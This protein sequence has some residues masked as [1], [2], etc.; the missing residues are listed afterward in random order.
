MSNVIKF[1][2][3]DGAENVLL[4]E[5]ANN[6]SDL[7]LEHG[8]NVALGAVCLAA[9]RVAHDAE[10]DADQMAEYIKG[11]RAIYDQLA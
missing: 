3:A 8:G 1:P 7:L 5:I 9:A 11:A 10:I 6:V 4:M 2:S